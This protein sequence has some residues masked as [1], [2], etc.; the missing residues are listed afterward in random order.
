MT[1]GLPERITLQKAAAAV[2]E[3]LDVLGILGRA[4]LGILSM[5]AEE[6]RS[7]HREQT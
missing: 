3:L 6:Y 4:P 5:F 7:P 1:S 2:Q